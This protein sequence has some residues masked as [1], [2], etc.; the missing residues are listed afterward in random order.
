MRETRPSGLMSGDG[1]RSDANR[2]QATAPILDSTFGR[3][4]S[5]SRLDI[6]RLDDRPPFLDFGLVKGG[7]RLGR[8]LLARRYL[9]ADIGQSLA[10]FRIGERIHYSGVELRNDVLRRALGREKS[11]PSRN[12][13][14]G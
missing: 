13:K 1:K 6:R 10:H 14:S 7:E 2:P 11:K 3:V 8:L 9:L 4:P 12:M 5:H